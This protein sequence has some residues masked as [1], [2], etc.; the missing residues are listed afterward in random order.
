MSLLLSS[1]MHSQKYE[2][3]YTTYGEMQE[4]LILLLDHK[5]RYF[6]PG[7]YLIFFYHLYNVYLALLLKLELST[8]GDSWRLVAAEDASVKQGIL[9]AWESS[10]KSRCFHIVMQ[11]TII[12]NVAILAFQPRNNDAPGERTWDFFRVSEV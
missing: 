3:S 1:S 2:L 10:L 6:A 5:Y 11:G 9:Q 7:C 8:E 4:L 12:L